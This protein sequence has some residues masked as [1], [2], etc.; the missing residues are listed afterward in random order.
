MFMIGY[1]E[2]G[3]FGHG[4]GIWPSFMERL[5]QRAGM[6]NL[7]PASEGNHEARG[8]VAGWRFRCT[9]FAK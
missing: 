8:V 4:G 6:A 2:T 3:D 1:P 5:D 9:I 7:L